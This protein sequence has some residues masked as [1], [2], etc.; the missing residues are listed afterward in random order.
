MTSER[1]Y[2]DR[3]TASE[4]LSEIRRCAGSQFDPQVVVA[5]GIVLD[6]GRAPWVGGPAPGPA[7]EPA[8][9]RGGEPGVRP[10]NALTV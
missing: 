2:T 6:E 9:R 3:R 10:R 5:L 4:A 1:P 7:D 8:A